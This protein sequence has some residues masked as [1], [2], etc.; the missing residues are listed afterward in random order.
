MALNNILTISENIKYPAKKG[1]VGYNLITSEDCYVKTDEIV[2]I[3]TGVRVKFPDG[4][5]GVIKPRSSASKMGIHV[6]EGTID[7]GYTGE[8]LVGCIAFCKQV[9]V[10]KGSS[11]AQLILFPMVTPAIEL[12]HV[13]P[14]TERGETGFG[15]TGDT[16]TESNMSLVN[17]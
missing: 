15:S 2:Y 3:H 9:F 17:D 5:Y 11:I 6:N 12:V 8:L 1:D 10:P 7:N 16:P 13:L 4:F 14:T